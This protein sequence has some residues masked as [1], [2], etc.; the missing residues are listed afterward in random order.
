MIG[1]SDNQ[2]PQPMPLI[3]NVLGQEN[4]RAHPEE[5]T[6]TSNQAKLRTNAINN[7]KALKGHDL[8]SEELAQ[9]DSLLES[10][11]K[12]NKVGKELLAPVAPS[13]AKAPWKVRGEHTL[14]IGDITYTL[15]QKRVSRSFFSS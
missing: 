5:T 6:E 15:Q 13:A 2:H 11:E 12:I 8:S 4:P 7:L 9:I 1:S 3:P 14:T 10:L